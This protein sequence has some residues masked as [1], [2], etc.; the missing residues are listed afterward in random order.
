M[1]TS[2][3]VETKSMLKVHQFSVIPKMDV[4]LEKRSTMMKQNH[5]REQDR[6]KRGKKSD[7]GI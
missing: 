7:F 1:S 5:G 6:K 2:P 4:P 3:R